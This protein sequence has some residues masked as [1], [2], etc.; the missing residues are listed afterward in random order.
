MEWSRE[1][2]GLWIAVHIVS[3]IS[4]LEIYSIEMD[5]FLPKDI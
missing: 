3:V 2:V 1:M 5:I 4:L